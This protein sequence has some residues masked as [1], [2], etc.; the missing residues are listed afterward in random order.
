MRPIPVLMYHHVSPHKGDTV[1][2]TPETFEGQMGFLRAAGY[3]ILT[4]DELLSCMSGELVLK[5][6]AVA[7]TFDDGWLDNYLF[8]Y[9]IL[10][11]HRIN[12][13]VFIV[14]DWV[15]R[16][17]GHNPS[18]PPLNLRGGR[19]GLQDVI[20]ST[21]NES[22]ALIRNGEE[23]RVALNWSHIAEMQESGLV[24]FY[25]HTKTHAECDRLTGNGLA[26]ELGGSKKIIE[27]RTGR[28]CPY[29]CWPRGKYSDIALKAAK[30][31]G[32][33]GLFTTRRGVVR[34]GADPFA[35]E[36][37]VIKDNVGWFR[38]R[39]RI[40]TNPLASSFYL[41]MRNARDTRPA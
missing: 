2:V 13:T 12:A 41:L 34:A 14:T 1:S 40:Y 4:P 17:S 24:S 9:P 22:K 23:H 39:M 38:K 8:A 18:S 35:I 33:R 15:E 10:R 36:R 37:I 7:V 21:H 11:E 28:P 30:N 5:E 25:S 6:K 29:L 31:A 3:R 27:T 20:V 19:V 26:E 16:A 32:Y